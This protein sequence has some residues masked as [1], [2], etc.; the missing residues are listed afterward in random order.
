M[1]A[2]Q[3]SMTRPGITLCRAVVVLTLLGSMLAGCSGCDNGGSDAC[4]PAC[5]SGEVCDSSTG[6][7][8][9]VRLNRFEGDVPGRGLSMTELDNRVFLATI[10]PRNG[11]LLVGDLTESGPR[12]YILR[13]FQRVADKSVAMA[14]NSELVLVGWLADDG[15]YRLATHRRDGEADRWRTVSGQ[16]AFDLAYDATDDFDVAADNVGALHLIFRDGEDARAKHLSVDPDGNWTLQT[17]D[18]TP[19]EDMPD[20]EAS[21]R[22]RTCPDGTEITP[23]EGLGFDPALLVRGS[24]LLAA[25]HDRDCGDLRLARLLEDGW[26]ASTVDRGGLGVT[27]GASGGV[28]GRYPSLAADNSGRIALAYHDV[29]RSRLVFAFQRNG[30]FLFEVADGGFEVDEFSQ[31]RKHLVGPFA[32]LVFDDENRP[33]IA[34]MDSTETTLKLAQRTATLSEQGQ[35][36]LRTVDV[37]APTGFSSQLAG[38]VVGA[39]SLTPSESGFASQLDLVEIDELQ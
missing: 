37:S 21:A 26:A 39:E 35:W 30:E 14:A 38:G 20:E 10:D 11:Y 3:Y 25:Y 33:W 24:D 18:P 34:Y 17:V 1:N 6:E 31:R 27:P 22:E 29:S 12:M 5:T 28:T 36:V 2:E 9:P 15:R 13:Q 32:S 8:V 23:G 4:D 16:G 7:C 19:T